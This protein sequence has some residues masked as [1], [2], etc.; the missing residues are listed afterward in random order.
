MKHEDDRKLLDSVLF[1]SYTPDDKT[2]EECKELL[3]GH[4]SRGE[5]VSV[6]RKKRRPLFV[7]KSAMVAVVTIIA[8]MLTV[9]VSFS[10]TDGTKKEIYYSGNVQTET[11]TAP[12]EGAGAG[13]PRSQDI[14]R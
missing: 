10:A 6:D 1:G 8:C 4:F 12:D 13:I 7:L 14:G 3:A 2:V 11:E 5:T 9:I